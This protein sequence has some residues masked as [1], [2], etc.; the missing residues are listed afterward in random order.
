[1]KTNKKVII[2]E[3]ELLIAK[4]LRMQFEKLG[5][6]VGA[7]AD[8][9]DVLPIVKQMLP[10]VIILDVQLKNKTSGIEAAKTIR[11]AGIKT[12]I[13]FTTGNSFDDTLQSVQE[14]SNSKVLSKP[15][16]FENLLFLIEPK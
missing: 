14:I 7:V 8:A 10:D 2:A 6:E 1:M 5:F 4:V 15:I 9:K 12:L 11:A 3:D 16:E 13:I